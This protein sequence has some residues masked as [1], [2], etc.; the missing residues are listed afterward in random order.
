MF[1]V[2]ELRNKLPDAHTAALI[3]TPHN[4]RYLT[5]FPSSAGMVLVTAE[6]TCFMTDSRYSEA[7]ERAIRHMEVLCYARPMETLDEQ[8]TRFGITTVL[9]E[10]E[11]SV[12]SVRALREAIPTVTVED[13]DTLTDWLSGLRMVKSAEEMEAVRRAQAFTDMGF[14]YILGRIAA[15]RTEREVALDLEFEIRRQGAECVAFEFIAVSGANSSL[16]HGVPGDKVIEDGDF[17]TMDFG[18]MVDGY[19]SDMTRTVAVG[20]VSD[21]QIE[22][23]ETVLAA[24]RAGLDRVG[25]GVSCRDADAAAR[26]VIN[27]AGY[28]PYFG[29]G[30]GHGVGVQI[31][32]APNLSPAAPA[33]RLLAPGHLVTVEPGIYL[34][35]QFGVRI[36]DM[37]YI[38]ADGYENLTKSP[39]ELIIL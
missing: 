30:T 38:T 1:S 4:R 31:H 25:P 24:Q 11:R 12:S 8:L 10:S 14:S 28:G 21:R 3:T 16:P 39:K 29:H 27:A 5:G 15:G 35:G 6:G 18:A 22:V 26:E 9:V 33:D 20:H 36:E 17:I 2:E 34:P 19:C 32:E 23:Y 13:S 37:V 7:A